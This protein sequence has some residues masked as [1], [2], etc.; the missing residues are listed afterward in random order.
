MRAVVLD[1]QDLVQPGREVARGGHIQ[2][3]WHAQL[4]DAD[5]L[6][7]HQLRIDPSIGQRL[8]Q[9]VPGLTA[10]GDAETG[11][12]AVRDNAVEAVRGGEGQRRG[13]L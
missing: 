13:Q 10:D 4:Q 5:A 3:P 9:G 6:F 12:G 11:A 8:A 2:R 7:A 1:D